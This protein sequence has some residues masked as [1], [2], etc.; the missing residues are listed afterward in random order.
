MR[1]IPDELRE[2]MANDPF[3]KSCCVANEYC[4]GKIEWHHNLIYAGRQVNE[5][6]C[7][8]PVCHWHHEHEKEKFIGDKL[9]YIM[10]G[11]VTDEVLSNYCKAVNW[12]AIKHKLYG[13]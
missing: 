7:I 12:L 11:R 2:D 10:L 6:W 3:Y 9:D 13:N 8:L 5:K 4:R 1:K